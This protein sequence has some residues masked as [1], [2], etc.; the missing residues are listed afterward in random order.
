MGRRHRLVLTSPQMRGRGDIENDFAV[1]SYPEEQ[2]QCWSCATRQFPSLLVL[3]WQ[4]DNMH[5]H[6][7]LETKGRTG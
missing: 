1:H 7:R 2:Q 3:D 5:R 6:W 4:W